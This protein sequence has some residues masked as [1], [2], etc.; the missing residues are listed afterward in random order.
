MTAKPPGI[1]VITGLLELLRQR[2][3]NVEAEIEQSRFPSRELY[4]RRDTLR[5]LVQAAETSAEKV[6]Q[7]TPQAD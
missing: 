4:R 6:L 2:L 1:Q 7:N 3:A 5:A